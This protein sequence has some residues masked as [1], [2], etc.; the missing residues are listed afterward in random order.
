MRKRIG[1]KQSVQNIEDIIRLLQEKG[2]HTPTFVALEL[3]KLPPVTFD[4]IDVSALLHSIRQNEVEIIMLKDCVTTQQASSKS[5]IGVVNDVVSRL[6]E[7]ETIKPPVRDVLDATTCSFVPASTSALPVTVLPVA[8][9]AA[10]YHDDDA[11][12]ETAVKNVLCDA[13]SLIPARE[14][15]P[16]SGEQP[17]WSTVAGRRNTKAISAETTAAAATAATAAAAAPAARA[18][19]DQDSH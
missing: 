10:A 14:D 5:L 13:S 2:T 8:S 7:V 4:S 11:S 18:D 16:D 17:S 15:R 6:A 3:A 1:P 12:I 9:S 19:H